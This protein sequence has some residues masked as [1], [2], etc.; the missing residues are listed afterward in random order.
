MRVGFGSVLWLPA[1]KT[2]DVNGW[3]GVWYASDALLWVTSGAVC[4][5]GFRGMFWLGI[6]IRFAR[7]D[8]GGIVMSL[9]RAWV[10][11]VSIGYALGAEVWWLVG[12]VWAI[13]T[14]RNL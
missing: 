12:E 10:C 5:G 7:S 14:S 1:W 3:E 2:L 4:V 6:L 11:G 8:G 13:G 9:F